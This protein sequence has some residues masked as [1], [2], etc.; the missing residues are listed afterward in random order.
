MSMRFSRAHS[1]PKNILLS[2]AV[3]RSYNSVKDMQRYTDA[4]RQQN[5]RVAV[6]PTMGYLHEGHL[7]LVRIAK[8]HAD[9][10][11]V[12]IFVN[13]TQFGPTEDSKTYP[14]D[15]DRDVKLVTSAGA[16]C[17]YAP[18]PEEMYPEGLSDSGAGRQA[19]AASL[20]HNAANAF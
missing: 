16:D 11:I 9:A 19:H 14:R 6:V 15:M 17:V 2:E 18:T 12:T 7:S 1:H 20:R 3:C 5:K 13:P 4:L 10:V 8:E